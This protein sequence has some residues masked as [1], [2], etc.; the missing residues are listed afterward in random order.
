MKSQL[1]R[2][3]RKHYHKVLL[4]SVFRIVIQVQLKISLRSFGKMSKN[5]SVRAWNF[6]IK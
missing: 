3:H 2:K 1:K 5:K 6:C 4:I